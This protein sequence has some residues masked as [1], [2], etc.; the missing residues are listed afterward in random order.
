MAYSS[1][2]A[3]LA[4]VLGTF[5]PYLD[6]LVLVGGFAVR[7]YERHPRAT[8]A[9]IRVLR[10]FDADLAAP[11]A[12]SPESAPGL[13]VLANGA[14]FMTDLR[15]D[16]TPPVMKFVPKESAAS[17]SEQYTVEFL[18]PLT[19]PPA[20]RSGEPLATRAIQ[21]GVTAQCMRYL[22]LLLVDSWPVP[23]AALPGIPDDCKEALV[24]LPH[25]GLFVVQKILI[26]RDRQDK[27]AKDMAYIYQVLSLFSQDIPRLAREVWARME[28]IRTWRKWLKRFSQEGGEF[29]SSPGAAG[30]TDAYRILQAEMTGLG[31]EA[32]TPTRAMIYAGVHAFLDHF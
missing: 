23:I 2:D 3:F 10:T 30:V 16:H 5:R 21:P 8:P 19:G 14:G 20:K 25:P 6:R 18:V 12:L 17:G 28:A 15:G 29:F 22:D 32:D 9:R 11:G 13:A 26:A 4:H 24:R 31:G 7:L 1:P 27:R